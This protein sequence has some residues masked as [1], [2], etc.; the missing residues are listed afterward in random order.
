MV[1]IPAAI[2][3][4]L[5]KHL[6]AFT[7]PADDALVFTS[8]TGAPLH[9]GNFRRRYWLPALAR[10]KIDKYP[11]VESARGAVPVLPPARFPGPLAEPA[12]PITEQRAL[13]GCCGQ[14]WF[15]GGQG[16][17]ILLPR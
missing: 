16:D 3:P 15:A 2:K 1:V 8:P 6:A 5:T 17:G 7:A 10:A 14:A 13:R 9:H 11:F 12:V 4:E